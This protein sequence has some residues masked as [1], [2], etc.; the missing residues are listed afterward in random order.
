MSRRRIYPLFLPHAGCPQRCCFCAQALTGGEARP[1]PLDAAR[2]LDAILPEQGEGEIAF[3]GGS[4]TLLAESEQQRWLEL[5]ARFI[6]AGRIKALRLSTRPDAVSAVTA[7]RLAGFGVATVELGC[8]SFDDAVL[9]QSGRG[10]AAAAAGRAVSNLHGQG[11]AVGLHLMPGLPGAGNDEALCSLAAA[12][13]LAPAFLRIHPTVVLRGTEL[14]R[15][16]ASGAYRPLELD[17]AVALCAAMLRRCRTAGVPVIR[18]GLL[19]NQELDEGEAVVAGPYHPA[20][21]QLVRSRLW[22]ERL[23]ELAETGLRS[24]RIHPSDLADVFG[25]GRSNHAALLARDATLS[26]E[27]TAEVPRE[28]IE[29]AGLRFHLF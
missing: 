21:G 17:A 5:G 18:L 10:H 25:H 6:A 7:E 28:S 22:L 24:F 2:C 4:F 29:S 23:L 20:F 12:L 8:Q 19:G 9:M 15:L 27:R 11:I 13:Q 3:Y 1:D 16:Y 26:F 14:E